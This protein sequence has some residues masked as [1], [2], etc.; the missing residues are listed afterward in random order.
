MKIQEVIDRI[1]AYHPQFPADYAGCDGFKCGDPQAECTGVITAISATID[2]IRTAIEK[3]CNLIVVHEP[4]FYSTPDYAGWRA[5]FKNEVYDEK[6]KLLSDHGICVWRDHD[7]MHAHQPD[8]IFTGVIKWMG[9]EQYQKPVPEGIPFSFYFE[10]PETTVKDMGELLKEKLRLN[11]LRY[12][13]DPDGV[14]RKI[15]LVGHLCVN[16]FGTDH[17]D[18]N[19][20]LHEYATEVIRLME[21]GVDA[22]IPGEVIDWT[23]VS[24]IRDAHMLGKNKTIYNVGHYNWEEPGMWYAQQWIQELVGNEVPVIFVPAGDIYQFM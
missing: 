10:I 22:I 2:V 1:L 16:A 4:T 5:D 23:A 20:Y 24:Y 13:G 12:I 8:G 15:A 14:I 19:G 7:H 9:W 6:A 21:N 11:G 17:E 18:E 3:N